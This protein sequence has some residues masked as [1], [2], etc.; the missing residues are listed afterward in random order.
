MDT[1]IA[2][3]GID[4]IADIDKGCRFHGYQ[5]RHDRQP[6]PGVDDIIQLLVVKLRHEL[7][8][9]GT[10]DN[11]SGNGLKSDHHPGH[12]QQVKRTGKK[13]HNHRSAPPTERQIP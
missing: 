13:K 3:G 4:C 8:S 12:D 11:K 2:V 5:Q 1:E 10:A 7:F 9:P 6:D